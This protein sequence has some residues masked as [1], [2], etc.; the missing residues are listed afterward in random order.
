MNHKTDLQV[1]EILVVVQ[2]FVVDGGEAALVGDVTVSRYKCVS[3]GSFVKGG[4]H[5]QKH[6]NKTKQHDKLI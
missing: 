4:R 6:F 1:P 2:V 5:K 3:E